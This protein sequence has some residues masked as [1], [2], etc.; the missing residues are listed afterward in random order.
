[1]VDVE[2]EMDRGKSHSDV[3]AADPTPTIT[4]SDFS[5]DVD[6]D[7]WGATTFDSDKL[8]LESADRVPNN[9][10]YGNVDEMDIGKSAEQVAMEAEEIAHDE[11]DFALYAETRDRRWPHDGYFGDMSELLNILH[12]FL[13]RFCFTSI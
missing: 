9:L 6:V 3:E 8:L 1:M 2:E 10:G 12:P 7:E 4:E 13:T 11:S 5:F